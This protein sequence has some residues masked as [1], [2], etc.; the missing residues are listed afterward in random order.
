MGYMDVCEMNITK[1]TI[2]DEKRWAALLFDICEWLATHHLLW[3]RIHVAVLEFIKLH[4]YIFEDE[5][6]VPVY[7]LEDEYMEQCDHDGPKM[8]ICVLCGMALD[9]IDPGDGTITTS[10][11]SHT[12]FVN[13]DF[14]GKTSEPSA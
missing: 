8:T 11:N 9:P 6:T 10:A 7:H 5:E 13:T 1:K 3:W 14:R 12:I 2:I 4:G